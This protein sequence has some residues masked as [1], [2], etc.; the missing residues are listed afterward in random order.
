[1]RSEDRYF[2][3]LK[4]DEL[5]Q[6]YCGFTELCADDY[7]RIQERLLRDQ[8]NRIY[9]TELGGK[10]I[11]SR[12]P[13]NVDEFRQM[14]P[15]T[16]YDDYEPYL[17]EQREDVLSQKPDM[18]G[19]S[20]GRGGRFKWMPYTN[21]YLQRVARTTIA[22][23][24]MATTGR[25]GEVNIK[26]KLRI[27]FILPKPP[28]ASSCLVDSFSQQFSFKQIPPHKLSEVLEL[29]DRVKVGFKMA[30]RDGVDVIAAIASV[31][32]SI[33]DQL[34]GQAK[35]M[36]FSPSML[37]PRL[38]TRL[39]LAWFRSKRDKRSIMPKDLWPTQAI[40][41][42]GVDTKIYEEEVVRYWGVKPFE[43]YAGTESLF[44][45]INTWSRNGMIFLPDLVFLEFIPY[46]EVKNCQADPKYIPHT[47]LLNELDSGESYEVV[48]S[49]LY[50]MPLVRYRIGDIIKVINLG[51]KETG[52]NLPHI[53]F[54][55]RIG[56]TI[57]LA[58]LADLD[59]KTIWQAISNTGVKYVDWVACKEIE[60]NQAYLRIFVEMKA[61]EETREATV[62]AGVIDREL[63]IMDTDYKDI[64]EYLNLNPVK[65]TFLSAGT[66]GRYIN[67]QR[68]K[69]ADLA[70][71]KPA[72]VN[73]PDQAVKRLIELSKIG[74]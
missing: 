2:K 10:V 42:S 35:G 66:F 56:E 58:G 63:K 40:M 47:Y 14:V 25:K 68:E 74:G 37:H 45:A 27:L 41:T 49:H 3:E 6:R 32:V 52:V 69:G 54:Q 48:I 60:N 23:L 19:H 65:L 11:G 36:K 39:L 43:F 5:W 57:A 61:E 55:R 26:P 24:I 73:P 64:G 17:S 8:I 53:V 4:R 72:H 13:K 1:M 15:L 46:R 22:S 59:E 71:L 38:M 62:L 7:V 29:P 50:G 67:E 31:L 34:S 70:H 18:W 12:K 30:M 51:D 44:L 21:E 33:G 9:N 16:T 28:Y 20:T